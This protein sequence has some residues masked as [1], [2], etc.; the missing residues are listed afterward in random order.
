LRKRAAKK[1]TSEMMVAQPGLRSFLSPSG[2]LSPQSFLIAVVVVYLVAVASQALTLRDVIKAAGL[3]P[4]LAA[5]LA[6]IWIWYAL[7]A[8]RLRDAGKPVGIAVAVSVLYV[9]SV[10]LLVIVAGAFYGS[11]AGESAVD[12]N[13]T[14]ALNLILFVSVVAMLSGAARDSL[15]W[16][17]VAVLLLIAYAPIVLALATTVWAATRP[18]MEGERA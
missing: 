8:K 6:L 16:L 13:A 14:G 17:I 3:W 2:R 4:F 7:H 15:A 11:L 18:R 12:P 10:V 1:N 5:Q 9:L